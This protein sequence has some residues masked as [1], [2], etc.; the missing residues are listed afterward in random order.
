[1]TR[2]LSILLYLFI[3]LTANAT[4]QLGDIIIWNGDTLTLFC[5]PLKLRSDW[6]E[7]SK[8]IASELENEG[9][10]LY[11]EE[12][13]VMIS[14]ACIRGYIAEWTVI[15]DK[16]YLSNIYSCHD[17]KVKVD[18]SKVFGKELKEN[19]LFANWIT[20]KLVIPQ[21]ECIEYVHLDYNSIYETETIIE[22]K[23]GILV[24]SRIYKNY[25]AR[26]SKFTI[27]P[28]PNSYLEFIYTQINWEDLPDLKNKHI[29]VS[30]GIQPN[31]EGQID[32]LLINYT[33]MLDSSSLIADRENVFFKEAIRIAELIPDWDVIYQRGHIVR[34]NFT[35]FFDQ[36][37]KDKYAR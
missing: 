25:I 5:N 4:S 19:L 34:R 10:R 17:K 7:I 2:K 12:Y 29:Q 32:S 11:S 8:I 27:D 16:I 22:F 3:S 37:T 36:T 21:G 18:L 24:E 23:D 20:D 26:K 6:K 28:N 30:I 1:M 14:T 13:E 33:Y 35:V 9:R 15:N 31:Q